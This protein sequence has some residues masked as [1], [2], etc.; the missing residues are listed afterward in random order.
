MSPTNTGARHCL[1]L[2]ICG[3]KGSHLEKP[4][5]GSATDRPGRIS[6]S[7]GRS[8]RRCRCHGPP[9]RRATW[10]GT[11]VWARPEPLLR[12]TCRQGAARWPSSRGHESLRPAASTS[13]KVRPR[14]G[15]SIGELRNAR[16]ITRS[17]RPT[18]RRPGSRFG[19]VRLPVLE[20]G[21]RPGAADG[22]GPAGVPLA[23]GAGG[24]CDRTMTRWPRARSSLAI[25]P[26]TKPV[27]RP[28]PQPATLNPPDASRVLLA[29]RLRWR[30]P[31][32]PLAASPRWRA[33]GRL[34]SGYA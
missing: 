6:S 34:R 31:D 1:P 22:A 27:P 18:G 29:A 2:P 32:R 11:S 19:H 9:P 21:G 15:A 20:G 17:R 30:S 28:R 33:P 26:P 12:P 4:R 3:M 8:C 24:R 16:Q 5:T 7:G 23:P 13:S 14:R 10:P 25:A